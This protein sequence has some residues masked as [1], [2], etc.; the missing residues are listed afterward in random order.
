MAGSRRESGG[1]MAR[2]LKGEMRTAEQVRE[3]YEIEK[4]LATRLRQ[5]A[6]EDRLGLYTTVYDEL[7]RRVTHHPI[8]QRKGDPASSRRATLSQYRRV[9]HFLRPGTRFL[10]VGPGDCGLA[11]AVAKEVSQVY[12]VDV[13][14]EIKQGAALPANCR[15]ILS[16]GTSVPLPPETV[17]VA[18]SHQL[19]EH[20]HPDDALAQLR[21]I[22][23]VLAPGGVYVCLTP[24][25]VSGPHDISMYFDPVATGLHLKEYTNAEL[26]SLFASVGF[27]KVRGMVSVKGH[28]VLVPVGIPL[29]LEWI[30][31]RL[32]R[33]LG[34]ELAARMPLRA[35]LGVQ[36]VGYKT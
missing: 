36:L 24:N 33:R 31:Q 7:F 20:L 22:Y 6:P 18:Y 15:F 14:E 2:A 3:H 25:S 8:L 34:H 35:F 29:M 10:E 16:D 19:M 11:F 13:T 32:P 26:V 23:R 4:D 12:V 9:R 17:T 5:S 21:N 30:I 27:S 28:S 1:I